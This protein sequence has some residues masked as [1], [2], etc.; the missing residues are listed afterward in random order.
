[1]IENGSTAAAAAV[2]YVSHTIC[3]EDKNV[4][5]WSP[6]Q[7]KDMTDSSGTPT[8]TTAAAVEYQR[9]LVG[10]CVNAEKGIDEFYFRFQD[11]DEQLKGVTP[12]DES[13]LTPLADDRLPKRGETFMAKGNGHVSREIGRAHV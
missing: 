7:S 13:E 2:D 9:V 12:H 11:A 5:T 1:M 3:R 8:T 6:E 4:S 10:H